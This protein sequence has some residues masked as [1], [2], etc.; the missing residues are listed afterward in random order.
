M[1]SGGRY[2]VLQGLHSLT[3]WNKLFRHVNPGVVSS[4]E[5]TGALGTLKFKLTTTHP[6]TH[7]YLHTPLPTDNVLLIMG[8]ITVDLW[9]TLIVNNYSNSCFV[10]SAILSAKLADPRHES[11]SAEQQNP[12]T[13]ST[14]C[15]A[16]DSCEMWG[17]SSF[18]V[19]QAV[20]TEGGAKLPAETHTYTHKYTMRRSLAHFQGSSVNSS[21]ILQLIPTLTVRKLPPVSLL[22]M[23]S[24]CHSARLS[25]NRHK[26]MPVLLRCSSAPSPPRS[27]VHM[28]PPL[29]ASCVCDRS[30][31]SLVYMKEN[32]PSD[33]AAILNQVGSRS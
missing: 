32:R 28:T 16:P 4:A 10:T 20:T 25:I 31:S 15:C 2:A 33:V 6:H 23:S 26:P 21:S 3:R 11:T 29:R 22:M 18:V 13:P 5:C 24:S 1:E 14:C 7:V 27:Q 12:M 30:S 17:E 8:D 19:V 9:N